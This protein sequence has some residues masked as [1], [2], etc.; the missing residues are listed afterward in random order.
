MAGRMQPA[1]RH[2]AKGGDPKPEQEWTPV[3]FGASQLKVF[4]YVIA[5]PSA[6]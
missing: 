5:S 1:E 3:G 2:L 6:P 4:N